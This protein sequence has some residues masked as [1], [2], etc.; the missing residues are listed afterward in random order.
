MDHELQKAEA[1]VRSYHIGVAA[2]KK[3]KALLAA[4][5]THQPLGICDHCRARVL[6]ETEAYSVGGEE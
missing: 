5:C 2:L 1:E 3:L 4:Q 6:A